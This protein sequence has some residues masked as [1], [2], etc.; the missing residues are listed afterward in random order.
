MLNDVH[1]ILGAWESYYVILG[2]SAAA[3]TGLQFVVIALVA[4]TPALKSAESVGAFGTPTVV[5]FCHCLF[6]SAVLSAPWPSLTP[7]A[8]LL[9]ATGCTG[10]VY[11]LIVLRLAR[12]Q[13][14]YRPVAEDWLCHVIFPMI[15]YGA[16]IPAA[17]WL[18]RNPGTM[19]FL[20]GAAVLTLIFV[21]IHNAWDAVAYIVVRHRSKE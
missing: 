3:L 7:V 2:S 15:A 8:W 18:P 14:H 12:R 20:V 11:T 9:A 13:S 4:E 1:A 19:L 16:L 10:L 17:V 6:V 5:H 21:G